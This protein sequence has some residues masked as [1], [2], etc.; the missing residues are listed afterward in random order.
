MGRKRKHSKRRGNRQNSRASEPVIEVRSIAQLEQ[1]LESPDPVIID[2]WA[3]WCGPC[4]AMA[5]IYEQV[6]REYASQGDDDSEAD[7]RHPRF[8]KVNTEALPEV[9]GEFGIRSI[10]TLAV[11]LGGNVIDSNVGV[12][13]P[14]GLARMAKRAMDRAEGRTIGQRIKRLF[15]A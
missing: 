8:L 4:K 1:H 5:P 2:F 6:A 12:T 15:A 14:E 3:P 11:L 13:S 10:P 9:A 7:R